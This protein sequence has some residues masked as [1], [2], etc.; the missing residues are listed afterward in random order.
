MDAGNAQSAMPPTDTDKQDELAQLAPRP[1]SLADTGLSESFTNE[2]VAKHLYSAGVLT[3]HELSQRIALAGT[4]LEEVI[5]FLR[6]D[7]YI[8]VRGASEGTTGLRYALTDRGRALALDS[9][10]KSGYTGPA[11]VPLKE[12]DRIVQAQSVHD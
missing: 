1:R 4:V 12:Y 5:S 10:I 7:A 8:E 2:L 9:L 3:L 6:Q 11:P